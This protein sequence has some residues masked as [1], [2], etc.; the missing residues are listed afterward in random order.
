MTWLP[1]NYT[2]VLNPNSLNFHRS[3][4]AKNWGLFASVSVYPTQDLGG[5]AWVATATTMQTVHLST[6]S[7]H[8]HK[9]YI[10]IL[11]ISL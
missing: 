9:F 4:N 1:Y 6:I 8:S 3:L 5:T 7:L 10:Q 11:K 2:P